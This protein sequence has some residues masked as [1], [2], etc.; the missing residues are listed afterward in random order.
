MVADLSSLRP[1][2]RAMSAVSTSDA[3][4][5]PAPV[6]W[7]A[8][9]GHIVDGGEIVLLALKPSMWRP[10]FDAAGW[11]VVSGL[12]AIGC[13]WM[14]RSL[15][16]LS[17]D[18][19]CQLILLAG[20]ARF[21]YA[22]VRWVSIWYLL[23]N[24]RIIT[25][26]GVR[27]P[28]VDAYRLLEIRNTRVDWSMPERLTRTG[29]IRFVVHSTDYPNVLWRSVANPDLVHARIRRAIENAIDQ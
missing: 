24:R 26:S 6:V 9:P 11:L 12:A 2:H 5:R 13:L 17:V 23:T 29:T 19:T 8:M 10:L 15:P 1:R 18:A 3:P 28:N 7:A 14:G 16:G 27:S 21:G 20:L 4:V 22:I 25:V